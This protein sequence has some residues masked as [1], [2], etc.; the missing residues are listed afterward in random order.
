MSFGFTDIDVDGE[1]EATVF[2]SCENFGIRG[3]F[4]HCMLNMLEKY[5]HFSIEN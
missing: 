1:E 5:L 2:T 4:K 3:I